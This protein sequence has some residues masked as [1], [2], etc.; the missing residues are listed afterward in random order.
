MRILEGKMVAERVKIGIV[1]ARFNEFIT[2]KLLGGA[3]DGLVRHGMNE[4]DVDVAWV[5]GAF[6]IPLIA[7]K[8]KLDN[9]TAA[10]IFGGL[11]GSTS[12]TA[13]GLAAVDSKLVP[14]GAMVATFY[15]GLGCLLTPTVFT[16]ALRLFI[17]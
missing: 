9:P 8:I 15:T 13:G 17:H 14:Y 11:I 5:P 2:S 16:A 10:M 7:K 12:G 1:V 6:E 4:D 3:M